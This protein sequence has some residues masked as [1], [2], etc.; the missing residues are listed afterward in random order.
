LKE[1]CPQLDF[2]VSELMADHTFIRMGGIADMYVQPSTIEEV[3]HIA[4]LAYTHQIPLTVLGYG[5]NIIIRDGG[6][7]G[8]VMNMN[9]L[10]EIQIEE[11]IIKAQCGASLIEV[12]RTARD[13]KLSGL[14]FACG[15]PGSIGGALI[16]NAGAYGGEVSYVL[17]QATALTKTGKLITLK[18]GEF[19]FGYR[20]S[21]FEK[22]GHTVLEAV[23]QLEPADLDSIQAKMDQFTALRE[24]KQPLEYPSCGSVFKRPPN[25]FAGKLIQDSGLQGYRIGGAEVSTKHAGFIVN[26]DHATSTDYLQLIEHVKKTVKAKFNVELET[27]V[28]IIGEPGAPQQLPPDS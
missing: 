23:F 7:R 4:E 28:K 20:S 13:R 24:Q 5:T 3:Q 8:L 26:I 19:Q 6:I 22:E 2:T 9:R 21:I 18:E 27:E 11:N 1:V 10:A 25:L 12:S 15:I 14:E 16:M 17:K